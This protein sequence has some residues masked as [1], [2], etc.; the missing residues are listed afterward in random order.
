[1]IGE[2]FPIKPFIELQWGRVVKDAEISSLTVNLP[3][4]VM[5]QW[6]RVVKDAEMKE[7]RGEYAEEVYAS[8]GPRRERRGNALST[9]SPARP[10]RA[11]MGPRRERRGNS[12]TP[13]FIVRP[14][15]CFNG[16]AS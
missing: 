6:G 7:G 1:M 15:V 8:M 10:I 4:V 5:L 12:V 11:S 9:A 14:K 16:A 2:Q 13:S 3:G